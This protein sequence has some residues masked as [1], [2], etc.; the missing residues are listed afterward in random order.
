MQQA[1]KSKQDRRQKR[2]QL[3]AD[4]LQAAEKEA[5]YLEAVRA[6]KELRAQYEKE[7][8]SEC[9]KLPWPE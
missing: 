8:R 6:L 2:R 9:D 4:K 7:N 5:R 3:Q 1:Q